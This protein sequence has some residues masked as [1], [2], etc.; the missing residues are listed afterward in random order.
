MYI[1]VDVYEEMYLKEKDEKAVN[2]E[3]AKIREQIKYVINKAEDPSYAYEN[4]TTVQTVSTLKIYRSYLERAVKVLSSLNG[5]VDVFSEEERAA[6]YFNSQLENVSCITLCIDGREYSIEL[7]SST[8]VLSDDK[9]IKKELNK[10]S[11]LKDLA[12]LYIGNWRETYL[13]KDYNCVI[14]M[15]TVWSVNIGFS[16]KSVNRIFRGEGVYPYN[17]E[18]LCRI[19]GAYYN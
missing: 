1:S 3:I 18:E 6:I 2:A 4:Q 10:D 11:V 5:G 9:G 16:D 19:F 8:A 14:N 17:F 13:P 15:P 7:L 12:E